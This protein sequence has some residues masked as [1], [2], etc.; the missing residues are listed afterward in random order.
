MNEV[1]IAYNDKD[2]LIYFQQVRLLKAKEVNDA[3]VNR[4]NNVK[5]EKATLKGTFNN[6]G[7]FFERNIK[8]FERITASINKSIEEFNGKNEKV[9]PKEEAEEAVQRMFENDSYGLAKLM[10]ATSIILDDEYPF[11][12]VSEGL[13]EVSMILYG[14]EKVLPEIK[15]QLEDNYRHLSLKSIANTEQGVLAAISVALFGLTI[16]VAPVVAV[17][18]AAVGAVAAH[19]LLTKNKEKIKEEFK[20]SSSE[21]NAYYLALQ[22][23]YIQ[24]IKNSLSEDDFKEELDSILKSVNELKADLDYYLFVEKE[25]ANENK[26]KLDSFHKF[27]D[28]LVEILK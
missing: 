25:S 2:L 15:K 12:Y 19:E 21:T 22:L 1:A 9:M 14:D 8:N 4:T 6:I 3:N 24:R 11:E 27:D 7:H 20:K 28:R 23:T 5:E 17:A 16:A 18:S 13:A 26:A 10:F